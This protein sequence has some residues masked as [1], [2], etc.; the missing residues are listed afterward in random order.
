[1]FY[2][3]VAISFSVIGSLYMADYTIS[4]TNSVLFQTLCSIITGLTIYF[5]IM[6]FPNLIEA[7]NN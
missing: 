7:L 5:C 1:M 3:L 2:S 6:N 4:K